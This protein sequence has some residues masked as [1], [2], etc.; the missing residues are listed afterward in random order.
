MQLFKGE[1]KVG[2]AGGT[3]FGSPNNPRIVRVLS[4]PVELNLEGIFLLLNNKDKPGIVGYLGTLL[5]KH[6][7]NI[8]SLSLSRDSAGGQALS[9]FQLDTVPP[10]GMLDEIGRDADISN[11]RVIKL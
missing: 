7:V 4:Q 11:I 1:D 2:S 3:F 8:A 9:V 5:G 10:Q 6:G